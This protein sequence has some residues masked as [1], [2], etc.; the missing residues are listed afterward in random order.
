MLIVVFA[1]ASRG[2][3][4]QDTW[5]AAALWVSA[6]TSGYPVRRKGG[7]SFNPVEFEQALAGYSQGGHLPQRGVSGASGT[8]FSRGLFVCAHPPTRGYVPVC[9]DGAPCHPARPVV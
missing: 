2:H 4:D 9:P 5:R 3:E 7:G 8:F 1:F 6:D